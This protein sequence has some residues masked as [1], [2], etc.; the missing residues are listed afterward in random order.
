MWNKFGTQ[1]SDKEM[2]SF[3]YFETNVVME[4]QS[5]PSTNQCCVSLTQITQSCGT[6]NRHKSC[7]GQPSTLSA[8]GRAQYF[9][10]KL[11][12]LP[13]KVAEPQL[14]RLRLRGGRNFWCT[15]T[16]QVLFFFL[17][18]AFVKLFLPQ[19]E[20]FHFKTSPNFFPASVVW[21]TSLTSYVL[22]AVWRRS[23][24]APTWR[25]LTLLTQGR[26]TSLN[27]KTGLRHSSTRGGG[28]G[29]DGTDPSPQKKNICSGEF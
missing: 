26:L 8:T 10:T 11:P 4:S 23:N 9:I 19:C 15:Q 21:P 2:S 7:T 1:L 14:C 12:K 3:W 25:R 18:E 22:D 28:G 29:G 5:V 27:R 6:K 17:P 13:L 20:E 24:A 16:F